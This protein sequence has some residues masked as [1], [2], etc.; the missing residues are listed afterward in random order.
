MKFDNTDMTEESNSHTPLSG[1]VFNAADYLYETC[2][3][4]KEIMCKCKNDQD[5]KGHSEVELCRYK[6][7]DE[8]SYMYGLC[9]NHLCQQWS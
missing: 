9:R 3:K 7:C 6:T 2:Q 4:G 5:C 8:E 1:V